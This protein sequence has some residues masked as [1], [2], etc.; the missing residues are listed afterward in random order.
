MIHW[1][2]SHRDTWDAEI[3]NIWVTKDTEDK[4]DTQ[5]TE[6]SENTVGNW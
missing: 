2:H 1:I 6:N 4:E 3:Q 5:D